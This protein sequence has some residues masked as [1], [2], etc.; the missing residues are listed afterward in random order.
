MTA[1]FLGAI[2]EVRPGTIY[3]PVMSKDLTPRLDFI[4]VMAGVI[5]VAMLI[6]VKIRNRFI[7]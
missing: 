2:V 1:M 7:Y 6:A 3:Q 4:L 5:G